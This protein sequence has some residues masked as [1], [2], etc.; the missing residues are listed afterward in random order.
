MLVSCNAVC[1]SQ[2]YKALVNQF[3]ICADLLYCFLWYS[4]QES[5]VK[6][7]PWSASE[8]G[9]LLKQSWSPLRFLVVS[10]EFQPVSTARHM[11]V[12]EKS[13]QKH[14]SFLSKFNTVQSWP[15]FNQSSTVYISITQYVADNLFPTAMPWASMP[16]NSNPH[17][18]TDL[19]KTF[20]LH[21][22]KGWIRPES[23][24][25]PI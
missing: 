6:S 1:C 14:A 22:Q 17:Q 10:F 11:W 13:H 24:S 4:S 16:V 2:L 25:S 5:K 7:C 15:N 19:S 12:L 18:G 20:L 21:F 23:T 9:T 3:A 8:V